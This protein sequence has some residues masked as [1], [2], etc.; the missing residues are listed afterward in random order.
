LIRTLLGRF[1]YHH[2][3]GNKETIE[4]GRE[5]LRKRDFSREFGILEVLRIFLMLN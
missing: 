5:S 2:L 3:E 4:W 1:K